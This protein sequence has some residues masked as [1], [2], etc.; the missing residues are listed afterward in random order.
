MPLIE[1]RDSYISG[2]GSTR[3]RMAY[4][5]PFGSESGPEVDQGDLL[6]YL[7]ETMWFPSAA[8]SEYIQWEPID[9]NSARATMTYGEVSGS[10]VFE[11][12]EAGNLVTMS[13]ER[14]GKFNGNYSLET[15]TTPIKAHR[16]F[17]Q[18]HLPS[19]GTGIW[20]LESGD[21]PYIELEVT[22]ID[23]N[24]ARPF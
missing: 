14:F 10:A 21:F 20:K 23:L 17:W 22:E 13:A 7:N 11:F 5:I 18:Y 8:L 15:W 9:Y 3:V 4:L 16:D 12:N 1:V 19:R 2:Q 24:V 6:R